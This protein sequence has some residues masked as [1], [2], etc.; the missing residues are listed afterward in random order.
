MIGGA[1]DLI[2]DYDHQTNDYF[3]KIQK[4]PTTKK[5]MQRMIFTGK[6]PLKIFDIEGE[7]NFISS[8]FLLTIKESGHKLN[9]N[10]IMGDCTTDE[11]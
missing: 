2:S 11:E 1:H 5:K 7:A 6:L 4:K 3:K 10:Y 9:I 8:N